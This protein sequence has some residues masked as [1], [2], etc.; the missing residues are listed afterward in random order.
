MVCAGVVMLLLAGCEQWPSHPVQWTALF[1]PAGDHVAEH[2]GRF[3]YSVVRGQGRR[4]GVTRVPLGKSDTVLDAISRIEGLSHLSTSDIWIERT[5]AGTPAD[6]PGPRQ[7]LPVDWDAIIRGDDSQAS[8]Y[9][10]MPGDRLHV[11]TDRDILPAPVRNAMY[12]I[13]RTLG[14]GHDCPAARF[15]EKCGEARQDGS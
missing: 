7:I 11:R 8:N 1:E 15:F 2:H 14:L 4:D 10:L 5:P 12:A 3:Y 13:H 9:E 6:S